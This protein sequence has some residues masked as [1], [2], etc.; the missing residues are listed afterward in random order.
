MEPRVC[1]P[2]VP[3]AEELAGAPDVAVLPEVRD[4]SPSQ[5][6]GGDQ[7]AGQVV[8][9]DSDPRDDFR[10]RAP[11]SWRRNATRSGF[12]S[13]VSFS[14][15]TRL[16]NS[17]VSSSVRQR[18]SC[19][20]GGLSLIPRSVKLLIGPSPASFFRK[21][22]TCRSCIWLSREDGAGWQDAH[23]ALPKNSCS[24]RSSPSVALV[25][26]RRPSTVSLGAGGKSSMFC[27]CAMCDTWI[28]SRMFIPFLMA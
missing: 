5:R 10:H 25:G 9:G 15:R 28:R 26:S 8:V 18:P 7:V 24:P 21:R 4:H 1:R 19:M 16:K 13:F 12:S 17:T 27:I 20:Y 6:V 23:C 14:P 22:S 3:V 11:H 2:E